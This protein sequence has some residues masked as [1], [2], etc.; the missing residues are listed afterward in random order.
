MNGQTP[1]ISLLTAG[2]DRPYAL[3]LAAALAAAGTDF[4]FVGSDEV[5]GPELHG[6][7]RIH[8]LNLR[9]DQTVNAGLFRKI[10]RVLAYYARL[11]RYSATA[12]PKIFHILWNNKFELFDRTALMLWYKLLGRKIVFTAHNVNARVRDGGDSFLNRATLGFQYRRCD[13]IFLHTERMRREL[14]SAFGVPAG[15]TTVIPFGL[16]STVP[17]T[18]LAGPAARQRLGLGPKDKVLLFFG[19]IAPYKGVE[20]LVAAFLELAGRQNDLR[21]IIAGRPKGGDAYWAGIL[22]QI[23]ASSWRDRFIL[24]IEFVPDAETEIYFKAADVLILPYTHI[25]QSGVL[26]LGYNFGLP[27]IAADVGSLKEEI[28]EGRTGYVFPPRDTAAL[29]RA[30]EGF[31]AGD[32]YAHLKERRQDVRDFARERYSWSKVARLTTAVYARLNGK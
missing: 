32:L 26:F 31:F 25:F 22:D 6:S 3:G 21:L 1:Q 20:F 30:I 23:Y 4:D 18:A 13:H 10:K 2:R 7:P 27:A 5:D 19:N 24:K 15:K 9:G 14:V 11:I 12:R 28:V 29:A 17:D 8:F 16:N